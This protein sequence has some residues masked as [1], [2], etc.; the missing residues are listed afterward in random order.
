[1]Q[2]VP[3]YRHAL[4]LNIHEHPPRSINFDQCSV[5]WVA[6]FE[7]NFYW[8]PLQRKRR[9]AIDLDHISLPHLGNHVVVALPLEHKRVRQMTIEFQHLSWTTDDSVSIDF[10]DGNVRASCAIHVILKEDVMPAVNFD[11]K[12]IGPET[13]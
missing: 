8:F 2:F 3:I 13:T 5:E 1:M 4:F 11:L 12:R 9:R 10:H 6:R 7:Q